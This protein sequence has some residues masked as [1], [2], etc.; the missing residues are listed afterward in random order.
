MGTDYCLEGANHAIIGTEH[1]IMGTNY[2]LEG[3]EHLIMGTDYCLEGTEAAIIGT[4]YSFRCAKF[5][6][7]RHFQPN[8]IIN[9]IN[10]KTQQNGKAG[11][12]T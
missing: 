8:F 12:P 7:K 9:Q 6:K 3:T 10:Q 5:R 11:L 4:D 1:L 2:C